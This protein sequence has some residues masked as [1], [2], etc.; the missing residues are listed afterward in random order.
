MQ[1]NGKIIAW[2]WNGTLLDDTHIVHESTN[3]VLAS[4]QRPAIDRA[5]FH[6]Q[7]NIPLASFYR[8]MGLNEAEIKRVYSDNNLF[9]DHYEARVDGATL[10]DGATDVLNHVRD[11]GVASYILSNHVVAPIRGQLKRLGIE[12]FFTDVLA[13][14]SRE[15]QFRGTDKAGRLRQLMDDKNV[16][17]ED[18]LI[19]GDTPEEI[20]I[21]HNL[22]LTGVAIAGGCIAAERLAAVKPHYLIQSL[23]ELKAVLQERGF[24]S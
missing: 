21:A 14:A 15:T 8:N 3:A 23:P 7:Y 9:H 12:H 22:G 18:V 13:F 10:R 6:A 17:P 2:D 24:A 16:S 4:L 5:T 20:E 19:I 11:A 1:A